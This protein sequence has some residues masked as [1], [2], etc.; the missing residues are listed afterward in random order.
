[1]PMSS[2][3]RADT[4]AIDDPGRGPSSGLDRNDRAPSQAP[5]QAS[6]DQYRVLSMSAVVAIVL[7]VVS[8]PAL[9][10]PSFLFVA[11]FG[12]VFGWLSMRRLTKS[13]D[14]FTGHR[15]ALAGCL[16]SV[17]T[18]VIGGV[19][20]TVVYATEVPEGYERIGFYQLQPDPDHPNLPVSPMSLEM[21]GKKVFIK[22]YIYPADKRMGLQHFVL[23][24]DLG[25]CCFG[26]NPKLTD[27]VE[28][29]LKPPHTVDYSLRLQRLGGT[30]KVDKQLKAVNGMEGVYYQLE[31][32]YVR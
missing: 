1:M 14:E 13:R 18:L 23:I 25:T 15:L 28:V 11:G 8:L 30:L 3:Q 2:Q 22:G 5:Q 12:V 31:A 4:E 26:G 16:L 29:T 20:A 19:R 17:I 21:D 27:M 24:P 7:G 32:D 9:I 10:L 6:Y